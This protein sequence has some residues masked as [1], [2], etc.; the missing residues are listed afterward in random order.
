MQ[1]P[2]S[3]F[4]VA[5]I[6]DEHHEVFGIFSSI[7]LALDAIRRS[8]IPIQAQVY[9][10]HSIYEYIGTEIIDEIGVSDVLEVSKKVIIFLEQNS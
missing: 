4:L 3:H 7:E 8:D 2:N 6:Y 1:E 9:K 10:N 5:W